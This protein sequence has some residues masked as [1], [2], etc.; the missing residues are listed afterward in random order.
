[1]T[2]EHYKPAKHIAE[3]NALGVQKQRA[4]YEHG[5][6]GELPLFYRYVVLET[7]FDPTIIDNNKIAYFEHS[8]G[9]SNVQYGSVLPRNTIVARR[10]LTPGTAASTPAMFLFPFFPPSIS[11]P[12]QPGEHVWVMFENPTGTKNDMGYWMC[13]IVEPG[14]VEDVNHT[15]PPRAFDPSFNPGIKDN[16]EGSDTPKYEF[17]NG[18]ADER[19][20]G[21]YTIAETATMPGEEDAYE[22]LLKNTDGGRLSQLEPVP[23]YRKRPGDTVF[24]GTNN[25]LIVLGRDRTGAAAK[26][27]VDAISGATVVDSVPDGDIKT[28]AGVIDIVAGRGQIGSTLGA[29]VDSTSI[30]GGPTGF[31]ELGK[32]A[33]ELVKDE[34][35]PDF[36]SDRSRVYIAQKTHV[37]SNFGLSLVNTE[38]STGTVQGAGG[39]AEKKKVS[40]SEDGDGAIVIK[41]DKVRLIARSDLEIVVTSYVSRDAKGNIVASSDDLDF[42]I[43]AV[44]ANG[45]IVFRPSRKGYIKL[46]GDDAKYGIVCSDVPVVAENGGVTGP[47]LSTTMGGFFAGSKKSGQNDNGPAL[48]ANQAKFANKVLIK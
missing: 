11:L 45:D 1:M 15:H 4:T 39:D 26:Y 42:A 36:M 46:G 47:P 8:L 43:V 34:G 3:G 13:R 44:K 40:D 12:C 16:F 10:V 20:D 23:R 48:S 32:S 38:L 19:D 24:E 29:E 9:V 14:F 31:K 5:N 21:R 18:R 28:S 6:R 25:T 27:K 2:N 37:D 35:D 33:K 41:S 22:G 17:R 7:I 30:S